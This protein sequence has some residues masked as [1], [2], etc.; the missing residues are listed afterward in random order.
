[1]TD[2]IDLV[3]VSDD[4]IVRSRSVRSTSDAGRARADGSQSESRLPRNNS[5]FPPHAQGEQSISIL[6]P[7]G[8]NFRSNRRAITPLSEK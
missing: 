4:T 5:G 6:Q 2:R 3:C 8:D 1:M 7:I